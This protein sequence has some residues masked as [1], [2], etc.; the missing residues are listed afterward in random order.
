MSNNEKELLRTFSFSFLL[1]NKTRLLCYG[2]TRVLGPPK[3]DFNKNESRFTVRNGLV[4][5]VCYVFFFMAFIIVIHLIMLLSFNQS[6]IVRP[7]LKSKL[8][9]RC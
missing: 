9:L 4:W 5:P 1:Q 3:K 7:S 2:M 8:S 6:V